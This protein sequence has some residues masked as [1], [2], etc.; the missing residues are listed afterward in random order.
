MKENKNP[1]RRTGDQFS[2]QFVLCLMLTMILSGSL[3]AQSITYTITNQGLNTINPDGISGSIDKMLEKAMIKANANYNV[4]VYFNLPDTDNDGKELVVINHVL[5]RIKFSSGSIALKP[6]PNTQV[7]QGIK[8]QDIAASNWWPTAE[9]IAIFIEESNDLL[10]EGLTFEKE[11]LN[12][13]QGTS[14]ISNESYH[15]HPKKLVIR[16]NVFKGLSEALQ[17]FYYGTTIIENNQFINISDNGIKIASD[18]DYPNS[19]TVIRNNTFVNNGV[20]GIWCRP[21]GSTSQVNVTV[22]NNSITGGGKGIAISNLAVAGQADYQ[23]SSLKVKN[24]TLTGCNEGIRLE[25]AYT[26]W[27]V[28]NNTITNSPIGVH[29]N[30]TVKPAGTY[31]GIDFI[32][33][34][35]KNITPINTGNNLINCQYSFYLNGSNVSTL[36]RN[37]IIG[38][39]VEGSIRV[40]RAKSNVLLE[41]KIKKGTGINRPVLVYGHNNIQPPSSINVTFLT[42]HDVQLSFNPSLDLNSGNGS[43]YVGAGPFWVEAFRCNSNGDVLEFLGG[44]QYLSGNVNGSKTEVLNSIYLTNGEK[45][46]L[47]TSSIGGVSNMVGSSEVGYTGQLT[48]PCN[49]ECDSF[50]PQIGKKYW[51]SAWVSEAQAQQVLSYQNARLSV[52]FLGSNQPA[53]EFRPTGRIIEGWQRIVGEFVIPVGTL[54]LRINLVNEASG[55]NPDYPVVPAYFDDIRV[56]PFN[57]SLKSYVYDPETYWLNAEL[58]NNNYATYYE[59]DQEGGLI[60]VKKETAR[61]I[62]TIQETRSSNTKN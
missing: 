8:V 53:I 28:E 49:E 18:D 15:A 13:A 4:T 51:I 24:N 6:H 41:N 47:I 29:V 46:G 26:S 22:E 55:G 25:N 61:G 38:Y 5:N 17:L 32:E 3:S 48:V 34:N 2:F 20:Y 31:F 56:H 33:N 23:F 50:K 62:M 54:D 60:R 10:I 21:P 16:N 57:G 7:T 12:G 27:K 35:T 11:N 58:D 39:D 59:Y 42:S 1:N 43:T 9:A 45:I 40:H 44:W 19:I 30:T 37:R 14:A 36:Y 52:E